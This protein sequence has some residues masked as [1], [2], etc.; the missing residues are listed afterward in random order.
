MATHNMITAIGMVKESTNGL[1]QERTH[2]RGL[3]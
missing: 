2:L 3:R 1:I